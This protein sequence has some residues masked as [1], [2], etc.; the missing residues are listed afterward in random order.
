MVDTSARSCHWA[1]EC[2]LSATRREMHLWRDLTNNIN[3]YKHGFISC[4][5][6]QTWRSA[7][8]LKLIHWVWVTIMRAYRSQLHIVRLLKW[9][10]V[11][12]QFAEQSI[13]NIVVILNNSVFCRFNKLWKALYYRI[14][15]HSNS[16]VESNQGMHAFKQTQSDTFC[17]LIWG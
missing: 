4:L 17:W 2:F 12:V 14:E 13:F 5:T 10:L 7:E 16:Q 1:P 6:W 8:R 3:T 15:A 11:R 9:K